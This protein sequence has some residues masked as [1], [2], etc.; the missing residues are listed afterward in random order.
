MSALEQHQL[1]ALNR[2]IAE[3]GPRNRFYRRKLS[4]AGVLDGFS[5]LGDFRTR[6][7]FT[8]KAE[9][10]RDQLEHPPYGSTLT[11]PAETYS[12]FHQTSGTS[13]RP[14]V[15]VDD[16]A[17]WQWIVDNWKTVWQKA[18][19]VPGNAA[20]FAFSFGPFLGFWLAFESAIQLGMLAIP[21][22]GM[23]SVDRLKFLLARRP[24]ILCCTP[25]YALRLADVAREHGISLQDSGV[26]LIMVGGEPGGSVPELRARIE[27]GWPGARVV[28]HHGMT[29]IGPVSYG[30]PDQPTLLYLLH[31]AYICE[32]LKP[33]TDEKVNFGDTGELVLTALGRDACPLLRYRT[34]DLVRPVAIAGEPAESFGLDGGILGRIDDMVIVRGVNLYPSAVDAVVRTVPG[35][36]EYVVEIDRR[37]TLAEV[38]LRFEAE[39]SSADPTEQLVGKL[40]EAFH[41]RVAVEQVAPGI[42]PVFEVKARRWKILS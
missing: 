2:L 15:W 35:I 37:G 5:S 17:S 31:T 20:F 25:T 3:I 14:L 29:E 8:T 33:G 7:P 24:R 1:A 16:R 9:L 11:Y 41:L 42:L 19:A 12:R 4:D 30:Y 32:V 26:Q 27:R 23:G 10:A 40:R 18:G 39:S 13:G 28:D 6:M 21:A 22:G 34:G 38:S 36:R